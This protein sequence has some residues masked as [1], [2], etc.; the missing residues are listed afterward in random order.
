M[1][2]YTDDELD[3]VSEIFNIGVNKAAASLGVLVDREIS[4]SVPNLCLIQAIDLVSELCMTT[5]TVCGVFKRIAEPLDSY[6]M[7]L[8]PKQEILKLVR[9]VLP[10]AMAGEPQEQFYGDAIIEI[11]NILIGAGLGSIADSFG[12]AINLDLPV[13]YIEHPSEFFLRSIVIDDLC[14]YFLNIRISMAVENT[15][16]TFYWDFL[17]PDNTFAFLKNHMSR[18]MA[19]PTGQCG[20]ALV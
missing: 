8:F 6:A 17:L 19:G 2:S 18:L 12:I 11:G 4:L 13:V 5:D 15:A 7:I 14:E 10:P 20:N 3:F 16:L 1:I 9:Y